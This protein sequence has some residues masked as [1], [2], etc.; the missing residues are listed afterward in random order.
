MRDEAKF[1]ES[2]GFGREEGADH[3]PPGGKGD[4]SGQTNRLDAAVR[5]YKHAIVGGGEDNYRRC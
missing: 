1:V 4:N 5:A 2:K 3:E